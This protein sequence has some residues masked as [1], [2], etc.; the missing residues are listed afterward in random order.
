MYALKDY[1][2]EDVVNDS[3]RAY[4]DKV[5]FQEAPFTTSIEFLEI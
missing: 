5:A 2:G 4:I 3:L 1:V